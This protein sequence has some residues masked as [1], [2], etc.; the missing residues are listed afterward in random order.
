MT[1]ASSYFERNY[2]THRD[3]W[4]VGWAFPSYLSGVG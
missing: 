4:L 2:Q 1:V 3:Y